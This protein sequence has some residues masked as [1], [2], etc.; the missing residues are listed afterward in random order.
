MKVLKSSVL[1]VEDEP[2]IAWMLEDLVG[3]LGLDIAGPFSSIAQAS[4]FLRDATPEIALLDFNL[5]DGEIFPVADQL[6]RRNVPLIF[7][8]ANVKS[9]AL[10]T[11]YHGAQVIAKPSDPMH[12]QQ[13]IGAARHSSEMMSL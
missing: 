11:R 6:R 3:S 12:L 5:T 13:A 1:I 4:S 8:T 2:L 10:A 7:H 9:G